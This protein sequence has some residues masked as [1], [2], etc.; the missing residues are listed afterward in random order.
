[1]NNLPEWGKSPYSYRRTARHSP[2][3]GLVVSSYVLIPVLDDEKH[4]W[5][6]DER[7]SRN[8]SV[9][10]RVV[11]NPSRNNNRLPSVT[12]NGREV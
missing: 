12:S 8:S 10:V 6:G 1:M 9:T 2:L 4:Y 11:N 7:S 3:A 5:V